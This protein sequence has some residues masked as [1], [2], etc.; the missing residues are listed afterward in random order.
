MRRRQSL[1]PDLFHVKRTIVTKAPPSIHTEICG[2]YTDIDSAEA[3]GLH[4]LEDEGYTR[5][6][7]SEYAEN[8]LTG[9]PS[10]T[11]QYGDNVLVHAR[12]GDEIHDVEIETTPNSLGV[13]SKS[14]DGRVWDNLFYLLRT[15]QSKSGSVNTEIRGIHLSKQAAVAAARHELLSGEHG[16]DWYLEYDEAPVSAR[17]D[18]TSSQFVVSA[19]GQDGVRYVM[20]VTHET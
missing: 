20:S 11:W 18:D 4:R 13:R 9:A 14:S 1:V 7:L 3:A 8:H 2:T 15:V 5:S 6:S 19:M 16:R 10:S 12:H 17:D